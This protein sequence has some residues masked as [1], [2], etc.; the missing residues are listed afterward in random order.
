MS[1]TSVLKKE[2]CGRM[3]VWAEYPPRYF[4]SPLGGKPSLH[5]LLPPPT[6][7]VY[8]SFWGGASGSWYWSDADKNHPG[9]FSLHTIGGNLYWGAG[10]MVWTAYTV[11]SSQQLPF[12][13]EGIEFVKDAIRVIASNVYGARG[14]KYI[15]IPEDELLPCGGLLGGIPLPLKSDH[16]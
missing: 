14:Q 4:H 6:R 3:P 13:W 16:R 15:I 10:R 1:F 2:I 9:Y 12:C 5:A 8:T 11:F 7:K